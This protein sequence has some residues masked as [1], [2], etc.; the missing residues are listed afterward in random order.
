M[1]DKTSLPGA[2]DAI[3]RARRACYG[4]Y[5]AD[6]TEINVGVLCELIYALSAPAVEP[7]AVKEA[8]K[9]VEL[10]STKECPCPNGP[11]DPL[12]CAKMRILAPPVE[13]GMMRNPKWKPTTPPAPTTEPTAKPITGLTEEEIDTI[14]REYMA[15]SPSNP[16][17]FARLITRAL[18]EK[19]GLAV[20]GGAT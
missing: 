19:N 2:A 3:E 4:R 20:Q 5:G 9:D 16:R 12:C 14:Q 18:A 13:Q 15:E 7:V 1:T 17:R 11:A 8:P 10:F 6:T